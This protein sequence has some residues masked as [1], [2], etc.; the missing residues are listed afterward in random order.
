MKIALVGSHGV[1]KTPL[2][3][4]LAAALNRLGVKVTVLLRSG[5]ILKKEDEEPDYSPL[6]NFLDGFDSPENLVI[7]MT[8]NDISDIPVRGVYTLA[9]ENA[10]D[11]D[12]SFKL[13]FLEQ[14]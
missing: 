2:C 5:R 6:L 14:W 8:A 9:L 13:C 4:E 1:G 3:F 7:I 11:G 10:S 12:Y